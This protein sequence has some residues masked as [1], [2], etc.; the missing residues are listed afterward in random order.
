MSSGTKES[1][2]VVIEAGGM[3]RASEKAVVEAAIGR[4]PGVSEVDARCPRS[5]W[6]GR[7]AR[8]IARVLHGGGELHVADWGRPSDPVMAAA[9]LG[10]R[11]FDG[12]ENTRENVRGALPAIFEQ[13]GLDGAEQTGRLRTVFGTLALYRAWHP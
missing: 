9:F 3:L 5:R 7:T 11:L 2:T 6:T 8:E 12:F 1:S 10:V 13:A 4:R